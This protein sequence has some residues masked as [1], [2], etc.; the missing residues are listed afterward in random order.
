MVLQNAIHASQAIPLFP[1]RELASATQQLDFSNTHRFV[2]TRA[3]KTILEV[4][5]PFNVKSVR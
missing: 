2:S 3:Q 1:L 4:L 5:L